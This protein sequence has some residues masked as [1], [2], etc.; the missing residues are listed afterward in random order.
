MKIQWRDVRKTIQPWFCGTIRA[1]HFNYSRI[2]WWWSFFLLAGLW[3]SKPQHPSASCCTHKWRHAKRK[4]DTRISC[5]RNTTW[6][7]CAVKMSRTRHGHKITS[8]KTFPRHFNETSRTEAKRG[9]V[10]KLTRTHPY[11]TLY[12]VHCTLYTVH[13]TRYA[14][15]YTVH[16]TLYSNRSENFRNNNQF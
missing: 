8:R 9:R 13:C 1:F 4:N 6:Q 2:S 12:A 15:Q 14:V 11:Y 7:Y 10:K 5:W 16:G 3:I